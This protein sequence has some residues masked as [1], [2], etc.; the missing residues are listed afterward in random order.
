MSDSHWGFIIVAYIVTACVI[1]GMVLKI[2]LD[3]RGLKQALDKMAATTRD[4][5]A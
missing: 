5:I 3:Y 1:G 2:L 4:D